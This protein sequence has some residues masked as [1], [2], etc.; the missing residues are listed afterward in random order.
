MSFSGKF[1]ITKQD[2][3]QYNYFRMQRKLTGLAAMTFVI[4]ALLIALIRY[5]QGVSI[6]S[7]V[8]GALAVAAGG[9]ALLIGFQML[10]VVFRVNGLYKKGTMSDFTVHYVVDQTGIHA[11][12]ERGDADYAWKQILLARETRHAFYLIAGKDRAVVVPKGQLAGEKELNALR[13][14]F[15]KYVAA[16]RAQVA[17]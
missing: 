4:L 9:A 17:K 12:S 13:A 6:Q 1:T 2:N 11:K 7:A 10:S 16:G 14:L 5:G 15:R 3:I 8:L